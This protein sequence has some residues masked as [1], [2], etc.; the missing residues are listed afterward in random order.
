M[1]SSS[2]RWSLAWLLPCL[3]A[4]AAFP[5]APAAAQAPADPIHTLPSPPRTEPWPDQVIAAMAALPAQEDGRVKPLTTVAS[6][7]LYGIHGSRSL[8]ITAPMTA[9]LSPIEWLLDVW[10]HLDQ[11]DGYPLFRIEN[12]QVYGELGIDKETVLRMRLEFLS[13]RELA[14]VSERLFERARDYG[15]TP[16]KER[17]ALQQ[18][19]VELAGQLDGYHTLRMVPELMRTPFALRG[20]RVRGLFGGRETVTYSELLGQARAMGELML[21][22]PATA[23][24]ADDNLGRLL[25]ALQNIARFDERGPALLPPP[26]GETWWQSGDIVQPALRGD[27]IRGQLGL[28]AGWERALGTADA[29]ARQQELLALCAA[30]GAAAAA[31]GELGTVTL[32]ADYHRWNLQWRALQSGVLAFL[33][34]AVGWFWPRSRRLWWGGMSLTGLGLLLLVVDITLRCVIR[35]HP[36]VTNLY[37]TFLFITAVGVLAGLVLEAINR[38]RI[39]LSVA[40]LMLPLGIQLARMFEVSDSKDTLQPLVAV[41]RSN[42]WLS[43]HVTTINIGYAGGMLAALIASAWLVLRTLGFRRGDD[44]WYRDVHRMVYGATCF[45]LLFSVVGTI[46]GG[47]WANESW[48]R[49]WGWDPKENGALLICLCQIAMLHGRLSGLLRQWGFCLAAGF[50]GMV[51]AFSWFH[52]NLLGV[53]LHNYGFAGGLAR[54]LWIY[55]AF[56]GGVLLVGGVGWLLQRNAAAA[57]L[58]AT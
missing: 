39:A 53:G 58:A 52:V 38:K 10:F 44:A 47:I 26:A 2:G 40:A 36:P 43:T 29:A 4:L 41:L 25:L 18:H 33:L 56:Q 15:R 5:A 34:A 35:R 20:E 31:R 48:G 50:T 54:G 46:L 32:E 22:Q 30:T 45:G 19:I 42:F 7:A 28:L 1:S 11:A 6:V 55:Y 51:V 17:S 14:P 27:D 9:T 8:K 37:D 23:N 16:E 3:F 12:N 49:F 57:A 24:D 13:Y 21:A